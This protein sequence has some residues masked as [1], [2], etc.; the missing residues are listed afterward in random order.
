MQ[1][2]QTQL[3]P[4]LNAMGVAIELDDRH[5]PLKEAVQLVG[6]TR[7]TIN[8]MIE[9]GQF[10]PKHFTTPNRVAFWQS[11]LEEWKKTGAFVWFERYG[12]AYLAHEQNARRMAS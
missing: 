1:N 7:T 8:S 9:R 4:V 6:A 12:K 3:V 11:E 10:P 5:V 2:K